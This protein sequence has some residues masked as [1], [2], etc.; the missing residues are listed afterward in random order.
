MYIRYDFS[1]GGKKVI[2][3]TLCFTNL[4]NKLKYTTAHAHTL[5]PSKQKVLKM[6]I[7]KEQNGLVGS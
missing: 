6:T 1:L 5:K 2:E 4:R 7:I 3:N